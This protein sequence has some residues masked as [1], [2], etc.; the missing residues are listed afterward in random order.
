V[1]SAQ[2]RPV[3]RRHLARG[4]PGHAG[5]RRSCSYPSF[6]ALAET[7]GPTTAARRTLAATGR[8]KSETRVRGM[9]AFAQPISAAEGRAALRRT[10]QLR[11]LKARRASR[12]LATG[13]TQHCRRQARPRAR[14]RRAA[15]SR[16]VQPGS[17]SGEEPGPHG[18]PEPVVTVSPVRACVPRHDIDGR[19]AGRGSL[20]GET[21][22]G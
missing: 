10:R 5:L 1:V 9:L 7:P 4:A 22:R 11:L 3:L 12:H 20:W 13:R 17:R 19:G 21:G 6:R 16:R 18:R 15:V 8:L 14:S 2:A